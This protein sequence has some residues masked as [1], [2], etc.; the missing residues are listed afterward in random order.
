[1]I[2]RLLRD[3]ADTGRLGAALARGIPWTA[4]QALV[5]FLQGEIGAGKTTLVR[6]LLRELGVAGTVRSPSYTLLESYEPKAG[7][8]LHL[9][10]YRLAGGADVAGLGLRDELDP[11]VLLLIEWPERA[12]EALPP[13]DLRIYLA[14]AVGGRIAQLDAESSTGAAWLAVAAGDA[15]F[16]K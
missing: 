3:A 15:A 12:A 16:Q 8:V 4:P 7:R 14:L 13:P 1:M 10:L 5:V 11:G 2:E 6:G 9:D